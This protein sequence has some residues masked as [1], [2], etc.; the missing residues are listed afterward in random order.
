MKMRYFV[1]GYMA[2][3]KTTYGKELAREKGVPFWDLDDR[4]ERREG[5]SISDIF[6]KKGEAYFRELERE[7]L[8][9]LCEEYDDFVLATGGGTPCFFDN[10]EYMNGAG[11]TLYLNVSLHVLLQ[12]LKR[13]RDA[14]P[15]LAALSDEDLEFFIREHLA[16][17]Q[18]FYLQAKELI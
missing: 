16:S 17:R 15:L 6:E 7:V 9:E 3:G 11:H 14:R 5:C 1:V 2:S 10:M 12:R 18:S 13:Q 8:H 4:V